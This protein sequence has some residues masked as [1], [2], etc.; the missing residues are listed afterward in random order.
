MAGKL[1][2]IITWNINLQ[3]LLNKKVRVETREGFVRE[4]R[5]TA[6]ETKEVQLDDDIVSYPESVQFNGE[7][8]IPFSQI[9]VMRRIP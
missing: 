2:T 5:V 6:I 7:D 4:A 3:S 9:K 1:Q 8:S